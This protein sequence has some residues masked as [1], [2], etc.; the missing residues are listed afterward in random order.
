[1]GEFSDKYNGD[2][3][4]CLRGLQKEMRGGEVVPDENSPRKRK[5]QP[6][7]ESPSHAESSRAAKTGEIDM[8]QY[9]AGL[10]TDNPSA[11]I[12]AAATP[13]RIKSTKPGSSRP[14]TSK[15]NV[16]SQAYI[17]MSIINL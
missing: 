2:I 16:S 1:M 4:A 14:M 13:K 11:R 15:N 10:E 17:T 12:L 7:Q 9:F 5:W 3:N 8:R 6:S